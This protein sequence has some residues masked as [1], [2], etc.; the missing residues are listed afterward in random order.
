[1]EARSIVQLTGIVEVDETFI[2]GAAKNMH[3]S[4]R[5]RRT[6]GGGRKV[7]VQ[8]ARQREGP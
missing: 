7:P 3:E 8:G 6:I 4:T 2:G 1:M 5:R